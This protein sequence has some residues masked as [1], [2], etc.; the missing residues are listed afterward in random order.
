MKVSAAWL[1]IFLGLVAHVQQTEQAAVM[2]TAAA[3]TV[4]ATVADKLTDLVVFLNEKL[5]KPIVE[6]VDKEIEKINTDLD[7]LLAEEKLLMVDAKKKLQNGRADIGRMRVTLTLLADETIQRVNLI[8]RLFT[9]GLKDG[10]TAATQQRILSMSMRKMNDLVTRSVVLV[11]EAK[12]LYR[13]V[14]TQ[15]TECRVKLEAF[16]GKVSTLADTASDRF[17]VESEKLRKKVY[18]SAAACLLLPP[19]CAIAYPIA[20]ATVESQINKWKDNLAN[21]VK[22]CAQVKI[23]TNE[24]AAEVGKEIVNIEAEEKLVLDWDAKLKTAITQ[25][26]TEIV[27]DK[28]VSA[29]ELFAKGVKL[30]GLSALVDSCKAFKFHIEAAQE[31]A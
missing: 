19:A 22:I 1:C 11:A 27:G 24:L 25:F 20:A 10:V 14:S 7:G 30:T 3:I 2:A 4:T 5:L 16:S 29:K 13:D 21:M 8:I 18:K 6:K 9:A 31:T 15:L 17:K 28:A 26:E 23:S 12:D